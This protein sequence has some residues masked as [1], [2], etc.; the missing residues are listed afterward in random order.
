MKGPIQSKF[1]LA[2]CSKMLSFTLL[3]SYNLSIGIFINILVN[4]DY[5]D[6]DNVD[7]DDD[8]NN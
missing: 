2:S 1:V 8:T 6:D 5:D 7:D 3:L 4:K